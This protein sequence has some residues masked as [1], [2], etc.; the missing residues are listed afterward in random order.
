MKRLI[1]GELPGPCQSYLARK[2]AQVDSGRDVG[3]LWKQ[4]RKTKKMGMVVTALEKMTGVRRRCMYCE[5]SRGT[6]IEHFRP[7]SRY[8]EQ[9]FVWL[10]LLLICQ[11]CQSHKGDHFALDE[12]S[13]PLLIDPT[14]ED[15]WDFLFF[16]SRTG[17]VTGRFPTSGDQPHAKGFHTTREATLPLNI[18]PVT[19]GRLR[20]TRGLRRAV[21]R[22]LNQTPENLS[23]SESEDPLVEE[24]QDLDGY[25][26]A[27]WFF[28]RDGQS[29]SPFRELKAH[30]RLTWEAVLCRLPQTNR[31]R[32]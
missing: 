18:E 24:I 13:A 9:S 23:T 32:S 1:R 22:F 10:N 29:E 28:E 21:Q 31:A 26:L 3:L 8:P 19:E 27:A 2:Q 20:T 14:A 11:G 25:G 6:T 4:S 30:H 17:R 15:P 16:D 5:D 7:K 12:K